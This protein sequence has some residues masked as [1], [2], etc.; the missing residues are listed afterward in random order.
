MLNET[1]NND[2]KNENLENNLFDECKFYYLNNKSKTAI[3][4]KY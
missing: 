3:R 4:Y 2:L 1:T